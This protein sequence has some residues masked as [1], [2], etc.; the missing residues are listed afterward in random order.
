M[1]Q[2]SIFHGTENA[3]R[4]NTEMLVETFVFGIYKSMKKSGIDIFVFYGS[5]I[6][7]EILSNEFAVSTVNFRCFACLR[8]HD[9]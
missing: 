1:M 3:D 9:A 5:T 2:Y 6:L 4:V 7:I 8:V